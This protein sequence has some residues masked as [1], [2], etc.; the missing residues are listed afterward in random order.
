M[1]CCTS[2]PPNSQM[3]SLAFVWCCHIV[4]ASGKINLQSLLKSI[5]LQKSQKCSSSLPATSFW[6]QA[7]P[8]FIYQKLM[9]S[10]QVMCDSVTPWTAAHHV[11]LSSTVFQGLLRFTSIES[12]MPSN[13][14][15]L[16]HPLLL[17]SSQSFPAFGSF[18]VS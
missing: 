16:C 6:W 14:L 10:C 1:C 13:H 5:C 15:I 8:P 2:M 18:S 4:I 12:V 7:A 17:L 3:N 9:F 11:S